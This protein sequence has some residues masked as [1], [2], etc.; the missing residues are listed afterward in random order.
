[1]LGSPLI[2]VTFNYRVGVLGH[3]HSR[4]LAHDASKQLDCPQNFRSTANLGLLDSHMAFRWVCLLE[5]CHIYLHGRGVDTMLK[6]KNNIQHFGGDPDNITA[7]GE[8]AGAG[9]VDQYQ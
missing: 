1:M 5:L 9:K 8:S 4:E 6:V 3:I 2:V 7:M